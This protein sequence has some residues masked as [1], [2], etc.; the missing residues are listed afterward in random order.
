[1]K[2]D[3]DPPRV[4]SPEGGAPP[5][6]GF[7]S[8]DDYMLA[9]EEEERARLDAENQRI[10]QAFNLAPNLTILTAL[11]NGED[12]PLGQLDQAWVARYRL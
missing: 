1:M 8:W 3:P 6:D 5:P 4:P 11:L 7:T 9:V 10:M 12:V 2:W